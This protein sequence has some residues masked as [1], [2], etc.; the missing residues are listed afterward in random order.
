MNPVLQ[1]AASGAYAVGSVGAKTI[2]LTSKLVK[3]TDGLRNIAKLALAIIEGTGPI[4][5][6]HKV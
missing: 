5:L 6:F 2:Q 3:D 4:T 1:Y